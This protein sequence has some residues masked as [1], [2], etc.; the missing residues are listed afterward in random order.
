MDVRTAFKESIVLD[1]AS[2]S[3]GGIEEELN[4]RLRRDGLESGTVSGKMIGEDSWD[5]ADIPLMDDAALM[6]DSL[7][8][9]SPEG[10]SSVNTGLAALTAREGERMYFGGDAGA[11]REGVPPMAVLTFSPPKSVSDVPL[12]LIGLEM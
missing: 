12:I 4:V 11:V 5:R 7:T 9:S 8:L 10:L 3:M 1:F 2:S 6:V